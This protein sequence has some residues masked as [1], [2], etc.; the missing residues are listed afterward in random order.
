MAAHAQAPEDLV[1][2]LETDLSCGLTTLEAERRLARVGPNALPAAPPPNVL[3]IAARQFADPMVALLA[4]AVGVAFAIG[5]D[6]E[7]AVIVCILAIN[8][9]IGFVHELGAE[10]AVLELRGRLSP[11]AEVI[12]EG[13]RIE[14]PASDVVPGDILV[15]REGARI[16]ADGRVVE[17]RGLMTD[18][19]ALT[20]ESLPVFKREAA[21]AEGT[22]LAERLSMIYAGTSATRGRARVVVTATGRTTE[23]GLV[24]ELTA[25]ARSPRTPL[26][27]RL[28]SLSRA[29]AALGVVLTITLTGLMLARGEELHE[30]FLVGV[31]VAVAAVPEGLPAT[32]T[33]ALALGAR[34]MARRGAIV[35]RLAAIETIGE[36]TVICTDK[37]GTL[38]ENRLRLAALRAAPGV[39]EEQLLTSALRAS[40]PDLAAVGALDDATIDPLE[41]AILLGSLE[42]GL[43]A[44]AAFAGCAL[45]RELPF[46]PEL[47]TMTVVYA[48]GEGARAYVKGAPEALFERSAALVD[49][50]LAATAAGW[51]EEG[52]RVLAV[53]VGEEAGEEDPAAAALQVAGLVA[54][55][56]PLRPSAPGSVAA[57]RRAGVA[58]VMLT[59]D[60]PRTAQTI[61]RA[62]GLEAADVRA[63]VSPA[64]K[65][66]HVRGLQAAGEVV[67]VTGDGVND[68]P[69]LRAAD[70][71]VAMGCAGTETA[72]EAA[73][74]VLTD[75]D[76]STIVAALEEGRRIGANIRKFVAFLLSANLAEVI[77]FTVA[78]AA[79]LGAPLTV[80]QVLLVNVLTDGLPAVALARDPVLPETMS[81]PPHRR[82]GLLGRQ[83][84]RVLAVVGLLVAAATM[85][86]FVVGRDHDQEHARTMAFVTLALAEL[87][88]VFGC[89]SF[90]TAAWRI[91]GNPHLLASVGASV[92]IVF[93][94]VGVGQLR[95]IVSAVALSP[96]QLVACVLLA[97]APS[98]VLELSK[99]LVRRRRARRP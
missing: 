90:L 57:A 38:T 26:Q 93:A 59:G 70:V 51:A 17:A 29:L 18:E 81:E 25:G 24:S 53:G 52:L 44:G 96:G 97:L 71:G 61:G 16:V 76:F 68:A 60:H 20:G 3:A 62:I 82:G 37:T 23:L 92:A 12:R 21:V 73:D 64:E 8:A 49:R 99:A 50:E 88:L 1:R 32:I 98:V 79:G 34:A 10:R 4:L 15:V 9:A 2:S 74:I 56:D 36:A 80:V 22:P 54:L 91:P 35:R 94:L 28:A 48:D 67:V 27:Q 33:V 65:L 40:S 85:A 30:A 41:R 39:S 14:I 87:A 63:R 66:E 47:R 89:R 46:E 84:A 5:D 31:A 86:A 43:T 78:V 58:V 72:R 11:T 77:V 95:P 83:E 69:A 13:V 55:H 45:V 6:L 42:R 75:D 7:A 19:S